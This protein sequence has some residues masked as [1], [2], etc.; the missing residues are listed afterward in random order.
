[1]AY[2][3]IQ[4]FSVPD[5]MLFGPMKTDLWAKEV[6]GFSTMLYRKMG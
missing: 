6:G 5:L 4:G 2:K 1:M 3:T